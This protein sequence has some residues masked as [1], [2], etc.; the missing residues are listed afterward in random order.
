MTMPKRLLKQ[1][2]F[3]T[4]ADLVKSYVS[5]VEAV[6]IFNRATAP[7]NRQIFV[8]HAKNYIRTL[9]GKHLTW[10]QDLV[11][12]MKV[13][14]DEFPALNLPDGVLEAA[15]EY[16]EQMRAEIQAILDRITAD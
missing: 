4:E 8:G 10:R 7:F 1:L 3:A 16:Q 13:V 15:E 9:D 5:R 12:A 11:K 6:N 14:Q 2:G